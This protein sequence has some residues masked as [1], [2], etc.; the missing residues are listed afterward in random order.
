MT[1]KT[2]PSTS[3]NT[4]PASTFERLLTASSKRPGISS[5]IDLE[6][7]SGKYTLVLTKE[8]ESLDRLYREASLLAEDKGMSDRDVLDRL[9]ELESKWPSHPGVLEN[10]LND[11]IESSQSEKAAELADDAIG[12]WMK[13]VASAKVKDHTKL[14]VTE[15]NGNLFVQLLANYEFALERAGRLE[16]AL[17]TAEFSRALDPADPENVLS[18]IVNLDIRTG[19]PMAALRALEP[20]AESL[21]PYV[22]YGRAL[23]YFALNQIENA[24]VAVQTALRQWPDVAQALTREWKGGT[25]MPKAGEQVSELQVLY[26]YYEVFGAAW[27][28]VAGA[29]EWLR[30]ASRNI[31][32][33]GARRERYLGLSRTGASASAPE[34]EE[35]IQRE[36]AEL[37]RKAQVL[38]EDE[39]VRFLEVGPNVYVYDLTERGK[40][41]EEEHTALYRQ[42]MKLQQRIHAIEDLLK[43]W[44]G[45]ANA[46]I[47]LARFHAQKERFNEAIELLEPVIFDLQKFWPEDIVGAGTI[48]ADW[49]GNKPLLSAYAY[50]VIDLAESGDRLSAKAYAKDFLTFNPPDN[51]GVRQKAI[52]YA[53]GDND[54]AEALRLINE[55]PDPA[56]AYNLFGRALLG[57]V[58]K[59]ND[60]ERALKNAVES[61]P[62]VWRELAADKHRMPHHYNPSWVR[63]GSAEEA[64]NYWEMWS[65]LWLKKYGALLWL[66]K[67]GRKYLA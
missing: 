36:Q 39:F 40:A 38:G 9:R 44:P 49:S 27:K 51:M 42:D 32:R 2:A 20:M 10:T 14:A 60:A 55:A 54:Y 34:T 23:A 48:P 8:G 25:P 7:K 18:S 59:A 58:L 63:Y 30:E 57:F 46:A 33:L 52:E 53:L 35:A 4:T 31:A 11:L 61:R 24:Q 15:G 1:S 5:Y 28:S 45:H 3:L 65:A 12:D 29:I 62:L 6:K 64:Y 16:E 19:Q 47:A 21:A 66:K 41:L 43:V 22:L 17:G 26:G 67:E 13:T 37:I 56:S 50:M